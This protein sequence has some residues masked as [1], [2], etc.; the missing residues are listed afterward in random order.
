MSFLSSLHGGLALLVLCGLIFL[1]EAG[2]P[3][4]LFPGDLL[5]VAGGVLIASGSLQ[6]ALFFPVAILSG[7]AGAMVGYTWARGVGSAAITSL[8]R[9]LH[10]SAHVERV[11][12]R[13]QRSG[14]VAVMVARL[15]P[16]LRVYVNL[17]CG[18]LRMPRT[19]F[20]AGTVPSS[21][22]WTGVF[23]G[24]G[25]AVGVPLQG[26]L[27]TVDRLLLDGGLL[28]LAGGGAYILIRRIPSRGGRADRLALMSRPWRTVGAAAV[29][30][31]T[32]GTALVG[33]YAIVRAAFHLQPIDGWTDA[34]VALGTMAAAYLVITRG[35]VGLTA[36][37][38][39]FQATYRRP[40]HPLQ[41]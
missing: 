6:P 27:K 14:P 9:R 39:L 23:G 18:A 33:F 5:L 16:G 1:E 25:V 41:R 20:L 11:T 22:I 28:V 10:A 37:E 31:G 29:D 34:L 2:V 12:Q 32:V 40:R 19:T 38:A 26:Y 17:V 13:L 7:V 24:L 4:P 15:I 8:A 21:I 30:L 36:G 3:L 35:G